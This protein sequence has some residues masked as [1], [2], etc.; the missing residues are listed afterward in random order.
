MQTETNLTH[1][2]RIGG[3]EKVR[4]LVHRFYQIMD[5]LPESYGIRKM[6]AE[7]LQNSE[8]KLFKFLSGWMGGP[9]LFIQEYGHPMLRRR[10]LPFA[11]GNAERDQWMLCMNKA[12][13]EVVEDEALRKDLATAFAGVADHMRNQ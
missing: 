4:T 13:Q 5:E 6:H 11:I 3:A 2:Q 9:Q 7:D 12:L 8:D 1:Y 10:H